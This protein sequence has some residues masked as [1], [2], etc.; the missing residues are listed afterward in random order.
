[1]AEIRVTDEWLYQ[2]M[3]AVGKAIVEDAERQ[4]D[5]NHE[6]SDKFE[7]KMNKMLRREGRGKIWKKVP[8]IGRCAVI[9]AALLGGYFL[10]NITSGAHGR[11]FFETVKTLMGDMFS[12]SYSAEADELGGFM[13]YEP[14]GLP[15]GYELV[16]GDVSGHSAF[17]V[18]EDEYGHILTWEQ[19]L[20]HEYVTFGID[21]EYD[22][23][24]NIE[25]WGELAEVHRYKEGFTSV[26][27]E[28]GNCIY[29]F[30]VDEELSNEIIIG[31]LENTL[32]K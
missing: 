29:L 4:Q 31:M 12:Y 28:Y 27:Y 9:I 8:G 26:Y 14:K 20:A 24:E 6:F 11:R 30:S 3:P 23:A 1:M 10:F 2:Y 16:E 32:K 17:Y 18:Y 5:I 21:A 25:V 19:N 13:A 15:E 7:K 22:Y